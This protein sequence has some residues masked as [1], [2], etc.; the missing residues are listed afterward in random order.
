MKERLALF[1]FDGTLFDTVPA[2]YAAY[3]DTLARH[4]FTLDETYFKEQCY[5]RHYKDFLP[6]IIGPDEN[7][8]DLIHREKIACYPELL[9]LVREHTALFDLLHTLRPTHYTALVTTASK[10]GVMAILDLFG[11]ADE[12]DL[13]LTQQDIPK[14]KP[15][16]DG[17]LMAMK[18]FNIPAERTMIF[19]D[20]EIGIAAAKASGAPYLVVQEIP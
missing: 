12:F 3:R 5:G 8:L 20:S 2:N 1:D 19:E 14:N 17:Y 4:G 13:I 9:N 18:H 6:P 7:L 16:P 15:A 11:R 10:A